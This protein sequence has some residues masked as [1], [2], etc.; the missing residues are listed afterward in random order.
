VNGQL[1]APA[2]LHPGEIA[3]GTHW[4]GDW[5]DLDTVEKIKILPLPGFGT[6]AVQ[7]VTIPP[8]L[9]QLLTK[10]S[11]LSLHPGSGYT[12]ALIMSPNIITYVLRLTNFYEV[13]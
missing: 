10:Y 12:A 6:P 4:I 5:A 2:A 3:P 7:P 11:T 8:E 1:R 9:S 13:V